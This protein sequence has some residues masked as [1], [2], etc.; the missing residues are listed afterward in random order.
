MIDQMRR[1][2]SGLRPTATIALVVLILFALDESSSAQ[3]AKQKPQKPQKT[4]AQPTRT[5]SLDSSQ[6]RINVILTQEG[7][8]RNR[9]PTHRVVVKSFTCK[10]ELPADETRLK[11]EVEAQ[12]ESLTNIDEAMSDFERKGFHDVL[13]NTVLESSKYPLIKFVSSSVSGI[14]RSG[15]NRSFTLN[16]DLT[17]H[18]A[19]RQV[20]FPISAT[21]SKEQI[22]ATGEAKLKQSDFGM[23]PFERGMGFIKIGDEVKVSFEVVAK[24]Q[25]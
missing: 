1:G 23:K 14:Q 5:Y 3:R 4:P 22:R 10:I 25:P 24:I 7:M 15:D 6:S 19:T 13:Q 16:G 18:G 20:S 2:L 9:Y 11:V 12:A 21:I 17:L 8:M